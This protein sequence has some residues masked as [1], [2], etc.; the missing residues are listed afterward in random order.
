M[1][2]THATIQD[3]SSSGLPVA[4]KFNP[5]EY[6]IQRN[7]NYAEVQVPGLQTPLLQFVRGDAQTLSLELFLDASDRLSKGK[8]KAE[9]EQAPKGIDGDL[10][11]LRKLVTINKDLHAPPVVEFKWGTQ[12]FQG[13][14][15]GYSEKFVMFDPEGSV[16]RA[17]VT[18]QLKKYTPAEI[19]LKDLKKQSPDRTK[20]RVVREGER[21]DVIASEEYGDAAFWPA[22]ARANRLARPRLLVPGTLLVIPP[23]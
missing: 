3:L 11:E 5:A 23:L 22:I 21:I 18:L 6:T 9:S 15:T 12:K 4:V 14:V 20:T 10:G 8:P 2:F 7:M 16:L 1:P 19:Q 13:V 17:R